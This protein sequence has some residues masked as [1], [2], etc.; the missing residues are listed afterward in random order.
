VLPQSQGGAAIGAGDRVGPIS[1]DPFDLY[2]AAATESLELARRDLNRSL[3]DSDEMRPSESSPPIEVIATP[4]PIQAL[5]AIVEAKE[6]PLVMEKKLPILNTRLD[7]GL[8]ADAEVPGLGGEG[9]ADDG[10]EPNSDSSGN[11]VSPIGQERI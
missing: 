1:A 2:K 3:S 4:G 10:P 5:Q 7:G 9:G 8:E 11:E 6:S